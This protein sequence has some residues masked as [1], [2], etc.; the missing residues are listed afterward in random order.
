MA[1]NALAFLTICEMQFLLIIAKVATS[2]VTC[3]F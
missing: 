3:W 1:Q 2:H